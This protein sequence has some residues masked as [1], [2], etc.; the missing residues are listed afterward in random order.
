MLLTENFES[1]NSFLWRQLAALGPSL[2]TFFL[3]PDVP[4]HNKV[5]CAHAGPPV[6]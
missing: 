2:N 1:N 6:V 4:Q 5:G 3:S